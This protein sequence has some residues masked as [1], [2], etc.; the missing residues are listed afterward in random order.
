[1][2][3][4]TNNPNAQFKPLDNV[5]EFLNALH[6]FAEEARHNVTRYIGAI[7][8]CAHVQSGVSQ[9]LIYGSPDEDACLVG[10]EY[11]IGKE[12]GVDPQEWEKAET[13]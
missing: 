1:M 11:M 2:S 13:E 4:P 8:F 9:C 5:C 12:K 7:Q 3:E 10:V 6:I